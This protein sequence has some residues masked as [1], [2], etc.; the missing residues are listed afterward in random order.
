MTRRTVVACADC[1]AVYSAR[2]RR[3]ET[4]LLTTEDGD[5]ACGSDRFV[6]VGAE[7]DD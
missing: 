3:D 7:A 5:C 1:G 4:F 6:E 2:K